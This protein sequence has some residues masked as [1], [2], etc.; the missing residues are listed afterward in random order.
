MY[1]SFFKLNE[2]H[3][4]A[5]DNLWNPDF[6]YGE[7]NE[8]WKNLYAALRFQPPESSPIAGLVPRKNESWPKEDFLAMQNKCTQ[9]GVTIIPEIDNPG[10]SLVFSQWKPELM[11]AGTPDQ[12]NLSYPET[13]PTIKAVWNEFLPWFSSPEVSIGADEYNASL[14]DD[15][16]AFVNTMS[17]HI[18]AQSNKSIRIWGTREPSTTASV[19]RNITIRTV[20]RDKRGDSDASRISKEF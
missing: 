4:H 6:L 14:A 15:Y 20:G 19:S 16:I 17:A 11:Q 10:H 13:V 5:S 7:G 8:G 18:G 1:A 12:L 2:F 9:H 3:L